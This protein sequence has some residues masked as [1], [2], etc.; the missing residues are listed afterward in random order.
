YAL[1]RRAHLLPY[2]ALPYTMYNVVQL[3][4]QTA[5]LLGGAY[6][7]FQVQSD[8]SAPGF[9]VP[10]LDPPADRGADALSGRAALLRRLDHASAAPPAGRWG[11]FQ[12]RALRLL[13]A[14]DLRRAF[15]LAAE[16][17]R[18]RERYG[19]HRLG[20]SL[21][22]ARRLVEA[23]VNFT[24]AFDGMTNGQDA[25]WAS[26]QTLFPR[27]R[28]LLPPSDQ[29]F[30]ALIEDLEARGLLDSTLVLALGE[31]GRTPRVNASAGR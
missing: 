18:L 25:N 8:P 31:F 23:G 6:D 20:Q 14:D 3:P 30:S 24:A 7:R 1:G 28:Q 19:P 5:G 26:H 9:R 10:D 22:L 27:H 29:A 11:T 12:E 15:D 16:P 2:V 4:G 13:A 17:D 21:L